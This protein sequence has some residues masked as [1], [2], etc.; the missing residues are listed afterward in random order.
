MHTIPFFLSP[1]FHLHDD[2]LM[3]ARAETLTAADPFQRLFESSG[4]GRHSNSQLAS[5]I[6]RC[7]R[8]CGSVKSPGQHCI[9]HMLH[10]TEIVL[11]AIERAFADFQVGK[12]KRTGIMIHYVIREVGTSLCCLPWLVSSAWFLGQTCLI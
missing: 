3:C 12:I 7:V 6:A 1:T 8:G 4:Q 10:R 5:C 9:L 2:E 11:G